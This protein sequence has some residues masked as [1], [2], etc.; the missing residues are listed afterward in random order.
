M[1]KGTVQ[2]IKIEIRELPPYQLLSVLTK[3]KKG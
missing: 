2:M 3:K 1:N